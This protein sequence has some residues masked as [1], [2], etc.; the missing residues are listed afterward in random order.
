MKPTTVI[1]AILVLSVVGMAQRGARVSGAADATG[2]IVAAAQELLKS[3]DE[4]GR[5]K[6]QFRW[7]DNDQ[8]KRWSNLPR[9]MSERRGL[10]MGDAPNS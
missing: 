6:V 10:R 4:A 9:P 7:K 1:G 2:R 8:R 3:L 5:A